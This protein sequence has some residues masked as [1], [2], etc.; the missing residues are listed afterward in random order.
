MHRLLPQ[1]RPKW[2]CASLGEV[3]GQASTPPEDLFGL[4]KT[5]TEFLILAGDVMPLRDFS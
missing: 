1:S 4:A 5:L 2:C 3:S